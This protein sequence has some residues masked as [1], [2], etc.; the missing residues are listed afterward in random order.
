MRVQELQP[1]KKLPPERLAALTLRP[2]G[3]LCDRVRRAERTLA[4][5]KND[6]SGGRSRHVGHETTRWRRIS[7]LR[8][9][10]DQRLLSPPVRL[11]DEAAAVVEPVRGPA[12]RLDPIGDE[13]E[14]P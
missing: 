6:G 3:Y 1:W 5:E 9:L 10:R 12:P 11:A 7:A 4:N 8:T 13:V 2:R 14:A